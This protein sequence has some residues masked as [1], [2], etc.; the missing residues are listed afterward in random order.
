MIS[1]SV[2]LLFQ[3]SNNKPKPIVWL[4]LSISLQSKSIFSSIILIESEK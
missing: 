2:S 1:N 4:I 3:R